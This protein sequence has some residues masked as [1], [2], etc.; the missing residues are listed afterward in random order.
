MLQYACQ[1]TL[2]ATRSS[3]QRACSSRD[4]ENLIAP[5]IRFFIYSATLYSCWWRLLSLSGNSISIA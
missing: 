1:N 4:F 2:E 5:T 3:C